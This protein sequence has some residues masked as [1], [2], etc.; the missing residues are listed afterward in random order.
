MFLEDKSNGYDKDE[1]YEPESCEGLVES[2][3]INT[4]EA[5]CY[6][7][8]YIRGDP[9]F[10]EGST[11]FY[12]VSYDNCVTDLDACTSAAHVERSRSLTDG[13]VVIYVF[14]EEA[15]LDYTDFNR[16]MHKRLKL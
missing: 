3:Y 10:S 8:G 13:K 1:I 14:T 15:F 6:P 12:E 7:R 4:T 16:P 5:F 9:D 11:I 2:T